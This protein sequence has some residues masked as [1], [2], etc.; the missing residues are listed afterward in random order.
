MQ[1][2]LIVPFKFSEAALLELDSIYKPAFK[3]FEISNTNSG[4]AS[5]LTQA[6]KIQD[7][8][9]YSIVGDECRAQL[10]GFNLGR[11]W[12]QFFFYR[13]VLG[14]I[15]TRGNP[16]LDS[17]DENTVAPFRFNV[18]LE[19]NPNDDLAWWNVD[20]NN[21]IIEDKKF[22]HP[23]GAPGYLLQV[24]GENNEQRLQLLGK[25]A[26]IQNQM[27][28]PNVHGSFVRTDLVHSLWMTGERRIMFSLRFADSWDK[29]GNCRG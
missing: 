9:N 19:G 18:M 5:W 8:I 3:E 4:N 27:T 24:M 6:H 16:H 12:Y 7:Q 2:C 15:P 26:H 25:P 21:P 17:I 10:L 22:L 13:T 29:I 11:P 20:R 23:S 28:V 1:Y 14:K